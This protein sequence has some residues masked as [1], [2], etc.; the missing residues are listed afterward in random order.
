MQYVKGNEQYYIKII[1][2]DL[3]NSFEKY[4]ETTYEKSEFLMPITILSQISYPS[5]TK[6]TGYGIH[7]KTPI[8]LTPLYENGSLQQILQ[9]E[10]QR[11]IPQ[12]WNQTAKLINI[13]GIASA[14]A[15]LHSHD[16]IHCDLNP[17]NVILDKFFHSKLSGFDSAKILDDNREKVP[18]FNLN[19]S[20]H[21]T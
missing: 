14:L 1:S 11:R 20:I 13:Y 6:L 9:K 12:N 2:V 19:N 18:K 7:D 8:I 16:I 21:S 3:F 10:Q 4:I 17:K 15:Y 5:I